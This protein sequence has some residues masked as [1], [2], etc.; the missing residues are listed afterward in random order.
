MFTK[1]YALFLILSGPIY[2]QAVTG[3]LAGTVEDASHSPIA[4]A[5]VTIT[6][7]NTGAHLALNTD[8]RG[9]Y[10]APSLPPGRYTV[11]V[12]VSGFRTAISAGNTVNV[13]ETTR[14]DFAMQ[15]GAVAESIQI[16]ATAP[17][18]ESTTSG[19][20]ATI[21]AQQIQTLPLN[22]RIFFATGDALAG[23]HRNGSGR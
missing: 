10:V 14:V 23:C 16:T 12:E 7:D 18:V 8:S 11:K 19:L 3:R 2:G 9:D 21:N 22:G 17:L 15:V 6:N 5:P 1:I 4:S 13:A 20:G